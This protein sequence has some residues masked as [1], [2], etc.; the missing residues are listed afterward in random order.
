MMFVVLFLKDTF[1]GI[2]ISVSNDLKSIPVF[3]KNW[4][5]IVCVIDEKF[6]ITELVASV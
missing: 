5:K 1:D 6:H 2:P 4:S 3:S